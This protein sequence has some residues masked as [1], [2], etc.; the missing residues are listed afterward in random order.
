LLK[1]KEKGT[2]IRTFAENNSQSIEI[3][4]LFGFKSIFYE[5]NRSSSVFS[6]ED[7]VVFILEKNFLKN[8]ILDIRNR[9]YDKT[10]QFLI[11]NKLFGDQLRILEKILIS[12]II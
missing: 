3:N 2:F 6:N 9:H 8:G 1:N 4:Q 12:L 5:K 10:R 7:S 11:E